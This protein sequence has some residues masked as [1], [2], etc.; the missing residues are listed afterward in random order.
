VQDHKTSTPT[1]NAIAVAVQARNPKHT[2]DELTEGLPRLQEP[3]GKDPGERKWSGGILFHRSI[4]Q[5][6][7]QFK[8]RNFSVKLV[9]I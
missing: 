2:V 9:P 6:V 7:R 4:F 3:R 5:V 1:E 8:L